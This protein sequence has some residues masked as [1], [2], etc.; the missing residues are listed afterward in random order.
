MLI[1][2]GGGLFAPN[3]CVFFAKYL[4]VV[5]AATNNTYYDG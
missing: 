4:V 3:Y 1:L 5:V 2:G